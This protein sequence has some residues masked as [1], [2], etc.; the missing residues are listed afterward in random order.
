MYLAGWTH[1][2]V[3]TGN[4]IVVERSGGSQGGKLN[5]L[6]YAREFDDGTQSSDSKTVRG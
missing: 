1:G 3:N 4:I 2:D 5:D 6:E